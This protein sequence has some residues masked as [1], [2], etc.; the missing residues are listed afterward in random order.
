MSPALAADIIAGGYWLRQ[1]GPKAEIVIA[2]I[3]AAMPEAIEAVGMMA[4]DR[5]DIGLL[6]ITSA[7]RLH[8]GWTVA[9][10]AREDGQSGARGHVERLLA[11]VPRHCGI[12]TV[13]DGHSA[14]LGPV[15]A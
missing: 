15:S 7:D 4:E 9:Q 11:A 10:R 5:R 14:T 1:P 8:A 2:C 6:A 12:V 13:L 3:G